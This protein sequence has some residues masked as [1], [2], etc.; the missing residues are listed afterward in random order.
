LSSPPSCSDFRSP[1]TISVAGFALFWVV[2]VQA[3]ASRACRTVL[4]MQFLR[5]C[6]ENRL[7]STHV[8]HLIERLRRVLASPG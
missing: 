6:R 5:N 7:F 4:L 3:A 8:E 2:T 1:L